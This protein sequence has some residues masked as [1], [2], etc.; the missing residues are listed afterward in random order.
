LLTFR[1][2][3]FPTEWLSKNNL[4]ENQKD[5]KRPNTIPFLALNLI[6]YHNSITYNQSRFIFNHSNSIFHA[7]KIRRLA[8]ISDMFGRNSN[9][10]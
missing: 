5:K 9:L 3:G 7:F 1:R 4:P 8:K 10:K 2:S 6:F